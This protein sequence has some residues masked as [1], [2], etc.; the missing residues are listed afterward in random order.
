MRATLIS[1]TIFC[2]LTLGSSAQS[3]KSTKSTGA[4]AKTVCPVASFNPACTLPF[5]SIKQTGLAIDKQCGESGCAD[6]NTPEGKQNKAKNN[7]CA[8][9]TPVTITPD[10]LKQLQVAAKSKGVTFGSESE[11]PADRSVLQ[12]YSIGGKTLSEGMLVRMAAFV[13]ETHP[14]DVT[15][16]ESV[17]CKTKGAA[18]NDVHMALGLKHGANECT[19]VTAELSP[20]FRPKAWSVLSSIKPQGA[21]TATGVKTPIRVTGQLFFDAS[22]QPCNGLTAVG[23]NPK[24]QS[25]WEVHPVYVVE[26]CK[27]TTL[28]TCDAS[29]D[30]AW[31]PLAK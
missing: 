29:D 27:N 11:I 4:K 3:K 17:N 19:S 13:I 1:L 6:P 10:D 24:R 8:T 21:T 9:G 31:T 14:A 15:N 20:H 23:D 16:G 26:V 25:L 7:F 22:H 12:G 30:S 5:D 28:Q 2:L 18:G